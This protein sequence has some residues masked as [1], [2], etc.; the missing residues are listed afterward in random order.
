MRV[1]T[2]VNTYSS[3]SAYIATN[4]VNE[5]VKIY[6]MMEFLLTCF[7]LRVAMISSEI[8]ILSTVFGKLVSRSPQVLVIADNFFHNILIGISG[9]LAFSSL[10]HGE[11]EQQRFYMAIASL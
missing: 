2:K 11:V 3:S 9:D 7:C 4:F 1:N 6:I 10:N 5:T 8:H